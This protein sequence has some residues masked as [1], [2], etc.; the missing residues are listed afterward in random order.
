ME[1]ISKDLIRRKMIEEKEKLVMGIG[2]GF[3]LTSVDYLRETLTDAYMIAEEDLN[4]AN[5]LN[6]IQTL[7]ET[8]SLPHKVFMAIGNDETIPQE[9]I[10]SL[11]SALSD[12]KV[13][14]IKVPGLKDNGTNK[15]IDA[16]V[17]NYENVTLYDLSDK[18]QTDPGLFTPDRIHFNESGSRM[19]AEYI[20]Q[21]LENLNN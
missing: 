21:A 12:C 9:T 4:Y 17:G 18:Y 19:F 20:L 10:D 15:N 16:V 6:E 8:D 13:I 1:S 7:K 14:L 5:V 3:M 11:L 2:D